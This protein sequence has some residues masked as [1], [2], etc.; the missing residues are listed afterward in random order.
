MSTRARQETTPTRERSR[1]RA[2]GGILLGLR[3]RGRRAERVAGERGEGACIARTGPSRIRAAHVGETQRLSAHCG[4]FI[5]A[6]IGFA[7]I[8]EKAPRR[9]Q[10]E[11]T[12]PCLAAPRLAGHFTRRHRR[13]WSNRALLIKAS[14]RHCAPCAPR[15]SLWH[16][17][18]KKRGGQEERNEFES[19]SP[20]F[21]PLPVSASLCLPLRLCSSGAV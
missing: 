15:I 14:A 6:A 7:L 3:R 19:F 21:L 17:A 16:S 12:A 5:A 18:H 9:R 20:P 2:C 11:R 1:V 4:G 13:Q 10:G 8:S